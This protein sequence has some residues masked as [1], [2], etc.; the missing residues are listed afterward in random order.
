MDMSIKCID[1]IKIILCLSIGMCFLAGCSKYDF[2]DIRNG[3]VLFFGRYEQDNDLSNGTEPIEW[4]V[5]S[6]DNEH[7]KMLLLSKYGLD[8]KPFNDREDLSK[9]F[10][11]ENGN[12]HLIDVEV[13]W[14]NSTLRKW[15]NEYFYN[16]AFNSK[17]KKML[18]PI[19]LESVR[20]PEWYSWSGEETTDYVFLLSIDDLTKTEYGFSE[21]Y[22]TSDEVRKCFPTEYAFSIGKSDFVK[23]REKD[24]ILWWIRLIGRHGYE[25]CVVNPDGSIRLSG[26]DVFSERNVAV[27]PSIVITMN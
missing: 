18:N 13:N 4:I 24:Y 1:L 10:P 23:E 14:D 5:L 17:E 22:Y 7:N 16:E 27:R 6:V 25:A 3:D 12:L 26:V 21:E 9:R 8:C 19:L 20:N 11:D 15:M 2:D